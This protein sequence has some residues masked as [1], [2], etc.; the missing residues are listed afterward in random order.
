MRQH[1]VEAPGTGA[2]AVGEIVHLAK[3][4]RGGQAQRQ[5]RLLVGAGHGHRRGDADPILHDDVV[6][7]ERQ[8]EAAARGDHETTREAGRFF[9]LQF[10]GA[11]KLRRD[12]VR[13]GGLCGHRHRAA[14]RE[15]GLG[16]LGELLA[17][18]RR[19]EASRRGTAQ[20]DDI[21]DGPTG[22]ELAVEGAAEVVEIIVAGSQAEIEAFNRFGF[23]IEVGRIVVAAAFS[24]VAWTEAGEAVG[25]HGLGHVEGG[26][27]GA[28]HQLRTENARF[29]R[30]AV[31]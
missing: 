14:G 5:Q 16:V 12:A 8:V 15:A 4:K 27:V 22:A 19:A 9:R 26:A 10:P 2:E 25:A 17:R 18:R 20:S 24:H 3:I 21:V 1:N 30:G 23:E 31:T 6:G 29:P 28:L 11:E 13:T 7:V